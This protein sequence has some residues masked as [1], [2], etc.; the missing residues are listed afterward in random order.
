M[1]PHAYAEQPGLTPESRKTDDG[2][3][4]LRRLKS[5]AGGEDR[6]G[7][8]A[9]AGSSVAAPQTSYRGKERRLSPRFR[10][11][12]SAEF[13]AQGSDVRMWGTL[14]DV[15][16]HGCYVEMSTTFPV[17]TKV[18]LVLEALG[19]RVRALGTVGVSYPFLGMGIRLTEIEPGQQTQ[20]EQLLSAVAGQNTAAD[21]T[22]VQDRG[23]PAK[24][25]AE[26]TAFLEEIKRFF[27]THLILSREEF[28]QIAKGCR[29][30]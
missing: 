16:L 28:L 20:L 29:R 1:D 25:A 13:K 8:V 19:I 17:G 4:Y 21:P 9:S 3:D 11:A 2:V 12:G 7:P 15:S 6:A 24:A 23:V 10:C 5:Q 22:L 30:S 14:T 18:E 26:P 27:D